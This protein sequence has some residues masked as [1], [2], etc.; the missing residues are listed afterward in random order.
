MFC[1]ATTIAGRQFG[2]DR[3]ESPVVWGLHACGQVLCGASGAGAS[4]GDGVFVPV[5]PVYLLTRPNRMTVS[6]GTRAERPPL[7][8]PIARAGRYS[9]RGS[10][11]MC[12]GASC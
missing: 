7:T 10:A 11:D 5:S 3:A 2:V 12:G 9:A 1:T 8:E 4:P 6:L